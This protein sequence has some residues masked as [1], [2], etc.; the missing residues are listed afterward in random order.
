MGDLG[1]RLAQPLLL[2]PIALAKVWGGDALAR[3]FPG[4]VAPSPNVGEIWA[5]WDGLAVASG[6]LAGRTLAELYADS[7]AELLG[8]ATAG[9]LPKT[10]PLLVKLL[11][12]REH[13]SIQVHPD[14]A[15]AQAREGQP[16]GKCEMWYVL[17]AAPGAAV[18][19]GLRRD[20]TA[21]AFRRALAGAAIVDA[22][23]QVEVQPGDVLINTPGVVHALGAGVVIF[24]LQQSSDLTYRLYDW[25]RGA[26]SGARRELHLEPGAEVADRRPIGEHKIWPVLLAAAPVRRLLLAAC[27]FFAAELV[28][29]SSDTALSIPGGRLHLV[30][31]LEGS[32]TVRSPSPN[33]VSLQI[34]SGQTCL[35]PAALPHTDLRANGLTRLI[36][37]YVPDLRA[38]VVDPLRALGVA[39][40][41]I[42]QLGGDGDRSDLERL[43]REI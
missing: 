32:A 21:E 11:D 5:I 9:P 4:V 17:E 19:H 24:E 10:F 18:Y 25:D 34:R 22:V 7:P 26:V 1:R 40:D 6:E 27:R 2:S 16:F 20:L 15:Y 39:D 13:L 36:R 29:L 38:D 3:R 33:S 12:A 8:P 43:L 30:T 42:A 37:S 14:D 28:E 35:I 23:E 31:A 41:R